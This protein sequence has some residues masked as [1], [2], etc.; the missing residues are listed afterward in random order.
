MSAYTPLLTE[1]VR[2][3]SNVSPLYP[4]IEIAVA[5]FNADHPVLQGV[6]HCTCDTATELER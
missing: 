1:G 5:K 2:G 4:F 3:L 6:H